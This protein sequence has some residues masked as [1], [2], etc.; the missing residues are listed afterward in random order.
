MDVKENSSIE[1]LNIRWDISMLNKLIGYVFKSSRNI[2]NLNLRNVQKLLTRCNYDLYKNR[3]VVMERV[4]F[5]LKALD[6]RLD[7]RFEDE[8]IIL[9]YCTPDF[10]NEVIDD[11]L[12][13]LNRYKSLNY[14]EIDFVTRFVEDR[15]AFGVVVNKT[16]A[17][18]DLIERVEDGSFDTY[19]EVNDMYKTWIRDYM[20]MQRQISTQWNNGMLDFNDPGIEEKVG[21]IVKRLGDDSSIIITGIQML[22]EMLSPGFRP[23]KLYMF[24]G[25]TGG[26][27][28][29]MLLKVVVDCARYNAKRFKPKHEGYKPY[30]LYLTMEN[31]IDESFARIWNMTVED[32]DV[33]K[34]KP[35]DIVAK[36]KEQKIICNDDIGVMFM[37]RAN[38]S[39][40]TDDLRDIIDEVE[41]TGREVIMLS[42]DYIKRILP[43]KRA[44]DE[45]EELKN[46]TNEIRQVAIDYQIPVVS[47]HQYNRTALAIINEGARNNKEDLGKLVGGENVGS[48]YEVME[49]PDMTIGLTLERK[50]DTQ[51]LYLAFCRLKERYRPSTKLNYFCQPFHADNEFAM[52]DDILLSKPLG[53]QTLSTN[54]EG[55]DADLLFNS[56]GRSKH[57]NPLMDKDVTTD[58]IFDLTPVG[59]M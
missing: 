8:G 19:A 6:A 33:E 4:N 55:A 56:R 36:L 11:I 54:M 24:L 57:R 25:V 22:N 49:N 2:N 23:G 28:S 27:K 9:E 17:M 51:L 53:V 50:R 48:A 37:Y 47:A 32:T 35:A 38:Q 3:P 10:S 14:K 58:D 26:Y 1:T 43:H 5:I 46:I 40:T 34:S 12:K 21:D 52:V 20:A 29:A 39:I 44:H 15:L 42:F 45:K 13:N 18:K 7:Q 41:M 30:V 16:Q 31:T 59:G